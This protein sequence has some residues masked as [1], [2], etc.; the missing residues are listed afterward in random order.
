MLERKAGML[1]A[2]P[3]SPRTRGKPQE[4]SALLSA[5]YRLKKNAQFKYVYSK[6]RSCANRTLSLIYVKSGPPGALRVGFSVSKK[7]GKAVVRN[8]VK[9]LMREACRMRLGEIR[10]GHLLVFVARASSAEA[11]YAAITASVGQLLESSGLL[12][13]RGEP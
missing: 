12:K 7:V 4:E 3:S 11:G 5:R 2:F 13:G 6:G 9:R 1:P 8:R 10:T